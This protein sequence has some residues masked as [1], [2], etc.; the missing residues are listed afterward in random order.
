MPSNPFKPRSNPTKTD[1]QARKPRHTSRT[2][3]NRQRNKAAQHSLPSGISS[4]SKTRTTTP[5]AEMRRPYRTKLS[6]N[7]LPRRRVPIGNPPKQLRDIW[8]LTASRS[9]FHLDRG[10]RASPITICLVSTHPSSH[11]AVPG[12]QPSFIIYTSRNIYI[13]THTHT[14]THGR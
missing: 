5:N 1:R 13:H 6:R 14:H 9:H 11:Q 4:L 3:T 12:F 8:E 10:C 7:C 2:T